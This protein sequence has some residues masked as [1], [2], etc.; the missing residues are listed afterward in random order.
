M[1]G[2]PLWILAGL[3]VAPASAQMVWTQV[4]STGPTPRNSFAMVYDSLRARV[5]LFGG[6]NGQNVKLNDTWEWDGSAWNLAAGSGP[7]PR[8]LHAMAY[9]SQRGRTVMFG[10]VSGTTFLGDTWE[11]DGSSWLPQLFAT[12]PAG[13]QD[14]CMAYDSQRSRTVLVGGYSAGGILNEVWE[15]NGSIWMHMGLAPHPIVNAEVAYDSQRHEVV[16][17]GGTTPAPGGSYHYILGE[18]WT[19]NGTTWTLASS[20]GPLPRVHHTMAYDSTRACTV[21]FG[22][23]QNWF[24]GDT[25]L[26]SGSGWS[27]ASGPGPGHREDHGMAYDSARGRVVLFGGFWNSGSAYT[28]YGDTWE[29]FDNSIGTA[30]TFGI[31][32]G[33]PPLALSPV[34]S[35]RPVVG[36]T[37]QAAVASVPSSLA[38]VSLGWSRTALGQFPLPLTLAGYGMPGCSLLQSSEAAAQPATITGPGTA[39]YSL[40]LP[41]WSGLLGLR[42]YLQGWAPAPGANPAGVIVSNG[43][44]W[45]IGSS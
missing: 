16:L 44:E 22:G 34:A 7:S 8:Y 42:V 43:L 13:R 30:L 40:A 14:H 5:V 27:L 24:L 21:L 38:F 3:L 23:Y 2:C 6:Q 35:A 37:A 19:W 32:C 29:L 12:G 33:V 25:W 9:D 11:W 36:A 28:H 10:G 31:G 15:W 39:T 18:T 20:S 17:F 1:K 45:Q 41:N 26:W 4:A